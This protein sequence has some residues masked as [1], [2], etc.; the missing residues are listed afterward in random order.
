MK[1]RQLRNASVLITLGEHRLLVDPMLSAPGSLPGFKLFGGD[2][3]RNPLVAL[4]ADAAE[5]TAQAT[6]VLIPH[7]HPDH[8]DVAAI[9]WI[10]TRRLPVWAAEVDVLNLKNKGIDARTILDGALGLAVEVIPAQ[11]GHGVLGWLM[12]PVS[13]FYLAHEQEPSLYITGDSVMTARVREAIARL[14]PELIIAPAGAANFGSGRE[15]IFSTDELVEIVKLSTGNVLFNHLEAID[16]CPITRLA[17]RQR[18]DDAGV[19]ERVFI[20]SD[21]QWLEFTRSSTTPHAIPGP[22]TSRRPGFQK[23]LTTKF[24]G[25]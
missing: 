25:T 20:P 19:G 7:E 1:I 9:E 13:G 21:G 10:K 17:L 5:T 22:S 24:A 16:H 4:P 6:D 15:L 3:R 11:H 12:G 8:L 2:R 14:E 18:M 23:W